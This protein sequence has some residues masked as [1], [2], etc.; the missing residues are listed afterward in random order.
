MGRYL[1]TTGLERVTRSAS[2]T[3]YCTYYF[4][5]STHLN[6]SWVLRPSPD[7]RADAAGKL[8]VVFT[9]LSRPSVGR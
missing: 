1:D 7:R 3:P 5:L 8:E 4:G 2:F 6:F 9:F